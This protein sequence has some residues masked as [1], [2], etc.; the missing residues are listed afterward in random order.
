MAAVAPPG[1]G[2]RT[3]SML[4]PSGFTPVDDFVLWRML[5]HDGMNML[6]Q[7]SIFVGFTIRETYLRSAPIYVTQGFC[8]VNW[9]RLPSSSV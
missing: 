5:N 1:G 3:F 8:T 4:L 7:L 2:H 9:A 6:S